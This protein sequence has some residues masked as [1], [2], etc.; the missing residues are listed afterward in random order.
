MSEERTNKIY[1]D[2]ESLFDLRQAAIIKA[3]EDVEKSL[4][5]LSSRDYIARTMDDFSEIIDTNLYK[6]TYLSLS[7][8]DLRYTSISYTF[9]NLRMRLATNDKMNSMEGKARSPELIVNVYPVKTTVKEQE[10]LRNLLFQKLDVKTKITIIDL[11]PL[12]MSPTYIEQLNINVFYCYNFPQWSSFHMEGLVNTKHRC[13]YMFPE[14]MA[15]E[16]SEEDEKVL[17]SL[18]FDDPF[19]YLEFFL[20]EVA[21]LRFTPMVYYSILPVANLYVEAA[22]EEIIEE[23]KERVD[24]EV[25]DDGSSS[26]T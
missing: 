24:D 8:S 19:E 3:S 10:I 26:D 23:E 14:L 22:Y 13:T 1:I 15:E 16:S 6:K 21:T 12:T 17:K 20:M 9:T 2:M 4:K 18:G 25:E 11:S 5:Y 7:F